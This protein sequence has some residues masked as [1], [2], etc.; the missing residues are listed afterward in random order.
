MKRK[1]SNLLV[2][3]LVLGALAA[4]F[5]QEDLAGQ[6]E[7]VDLKEIEAP[8]AEGRRPGDPHQKPGRRP[9]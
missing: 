2:L 5:W 7:F 3:S 6:L 9:L 8:A 4:A 1:I